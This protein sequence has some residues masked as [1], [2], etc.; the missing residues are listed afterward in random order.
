[1]SMFGRFSEKAQKAILFAQAEARDERHS[2]IG[3]EHI[4]LG[5]IKEG[6]DTGAQILDKLG[7]DYQKAK[8]ATLDIVATG[9]GPTVA[10]VSYTPRT[11]R[12]FELSFDV[13]KELGNRYVGTEH[14]LLGILREGQGVAI[15]VLKRLG[16]DII[17]LENDILNNLDEYEEENEENP[18]QESL[19]K[20]TIDLSKK[21]QEGKIDP[22]I[23]RE[24]EIK[25]VIQV[26]SRRTKNN[27]VLIGEPGVG[28]TAI[29]EGLALKIFNGDVPQIMADKKIMTLDV[30]AL[31]AGSKYRGDFEERL[32][33]VVKEAENN[34]NIILFIDEMHVIIGAGAAEGAMDASN[35]LKPMLTRGVIQII[36]ATTISEYRKHIEKDPAFERRLM[37]ITVE[38]PNV[39]DSIKI[40]MGIKD[41]YEDHHNVTIGE[42]AVSAAVKLSDRYLNDRFLPDKAID[43]IDEAASK[44]KIESYKTPDFEKKY[45]EELKKVEDDKNMAVRNQDFEL[46]A[47]LRD[48]EKVIE[49]EYKEALEDFKKE[50]S[51]KRVEV[52]LIANI[53]S[54]WSKVPVTNLTEKETERLKTL[55]EDLKKKVKGQDQAIDVLA[56][57][58]KR[59]RIGLKT[60]NKPIGSFIFVGPTGVGKTFLTKTLAEELFGSPE[61]MI[62]I[63][64]S[65]YM[66]KYT[67]SRLVGSPPGYVG[68][69]E[70]GQ[71]TEAVRTKPYSVILFDEIEK[72]HPDV[73]N[74]LLQIL[75]EGRLTDAQGRTVNFKDTVIV[76]TS[77]VGAN[78]LVKNNTLGF[79]VNKE[80]EKKNEYQKMKDIISRELKNTFRPEFLNRIDET[81]VFKELSKKEIKNIVG[82][83]LED[84]NLRLE[85]MGIKA[86]FT[87]K[88]INHIVEKGYDK[89]YGARPLQRTIRNL[90]EDEIADRYL[91]G[92]IKEGSLINI[93]FKNKLI[94]ENVEELEDLKKDK[95]DEKE[96]SIQVQ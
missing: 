68:Y 74:I 14:L 38:E 67:V 20:F 21:A 64:M 53:V 52:D 9:Q 40:L 75:D 44:L 84:L 66:E 56:R 45:K 50:E 1:M 65:E 63:D 7:I 70:G 12:I 90:L 96:N 32:K 93:D 79:S 55:D 88:L 4:L 54:E 28:K 49:R 33:N 3:S 85:T 8:K 34:K 82:L 59:A 89:K 35:I 11:K 71:L 29:A 77:N 61:N 48:K 73:F 42:D 31:I 86:T 27:P 62:R 47:S 26:L 2:Y 25:R 16:I 60:P 6:T 69:D 78:S 87:D 37:P 17:N 39:E 36:G 46:A 43:L 30:S 80:E 92:K 10:S 24:K 23:G 19:N 41:K 18:S 22:I 13:A 72:A 5:I 76:M 58:V 94:I 57:A 15:L 51:K 83:Q 91:D 81:V 95:K